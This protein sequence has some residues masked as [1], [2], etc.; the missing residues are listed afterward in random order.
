MG[1]ARWR[2]VETV[3]SA[4]KWSRRVSMHWNVITANVGFTDCAV[5]ASATPSTVASWTTSDTAAHSP[6]SVS[7]VRRM[8]DERQLQRTKTTTTVTNNRGVDLEWRLYYGHRSSC[9]RK[10]AIWCSSTVSWTI[11]SYI[12]KYTVFQ[13]NQAPKTLDAV[14]LSNLNRF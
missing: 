12:S 4:A 5:L 3:R 7:R 1:A 10:Y 14:I 2:S 11:L 6:G 9:A 13:K 8:P